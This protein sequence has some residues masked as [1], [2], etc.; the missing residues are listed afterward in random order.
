MELFSPVA[1][2]YA[3]LASPASTNH[4]PSSVGHPSTLFVSLWVLHYFNRAIISPL[5]TSSRSRSHI[6]IPLA[7]AAFNILNGGL[8]GWWLSARVV[9]QDGWKNLKFWA[10][11]CLFIAG[12]MGNI[13]HDEVLLRIRNQANASKGDGQDDKPKYGIP[14]GYLYH[15]VS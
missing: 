7:A 13:V 3:Y 15:Y 8:N 6:S 5:R 12:W 1:L 9:K 2:L 11:I 14:Y 10:S 4:Q